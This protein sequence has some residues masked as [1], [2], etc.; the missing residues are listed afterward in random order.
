MNMIQIGPT[1]RG[2]CSDRE[3]LECA[4]LR[5]PTRSGKIDVTHVGCKINEPQF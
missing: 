4:Y 3:L 2:S 5:Y 1:R